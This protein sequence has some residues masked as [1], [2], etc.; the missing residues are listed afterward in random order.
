MI[1]FVLLFTVALLALV[2]IASR[3]ENLRPL[4]V[5]F[6]LD[7]KL[8]EP[9]EIVTLRY[10]VSNYSR[11]PLLYAGLT[12]R[13]DSQFNLEED[14]AF[15]RRHVQEDFSG[16]RVNQR[17][18]LGPRS[19]FSGKLRIS[20]KRRG[21]YDLGR[22]Y[23]ESGDFLGLKPLMRSGDVEGRVICTAACC[24]LPSFRALGGTL[25]AI[26]VRRFLYD[27]PSM[28]LGYRE[29]TGRE[30]MKQISWNQTAKAGKLIVRQHDFTTDSAAE[31]IVHIDPSRPPLMEKC[32]SMTAAVCRMLEEKKIPY[33]M[34]SNGDLFSI[35][36]G[37][38]LSHL[39]FIQ[40]RIGLSRLTGYTGFADLIETCLR[41]KRNNCAFIVITPTL[42]ESCRQ[43]ISRLEKYADQRPIVLCAEEETS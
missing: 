1:A 9:G 42:T 23:L 19:R 26:S 16:I 8:V 27:D 11:L 24:D 35:T 36:E 6:S 10:T 41:H 28:V 40:R 30:P 7:T 29:Y 20:V 5:S 38:G 22:Y 3:W 15:L 4:Q 33:S 43:G 18:S 25:G 34:R 21:L 2:E 39:Y 37:L 14:E 32:L 12:L 31:L 17:F 13:L